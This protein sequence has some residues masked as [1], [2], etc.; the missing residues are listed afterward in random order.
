MTKGDNNILN[1]ESYKTVPDQDELLTDQKKMMYEICHCLVQEPFI[2]NDA[3]TL[4][5]E[6]L[7]VHK[8]FLYSIVSDSIFKLDNDQRPTYLANTEKLLLNCSDENKDSILKLYDHANLAVN[9][10]SSLKQS[11]EE[12]NTRFG[13][14]FSDKI[15]PI[16]ADTEEKL[17]E[18]A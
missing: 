4:I 17:Q 3:K 8:R 10:F 7:T 16:I 18:N 5:K 6:Y 14:L 13:N 9:Q 2:E 12:F 1:T 11:E 15:K